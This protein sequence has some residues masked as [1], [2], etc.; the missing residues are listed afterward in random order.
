MTTLPIGGFAAGVKSA[1]ARAKQYKER[2]TS[3]PRFIWFVFPSVHSSEACGNFV[4]CLA[5]NTECY[6]QWHH[7]GLESV[8]GDAILESQLKAAD[9]VCKALLRKTSRLPS[10]TKAV[11]TLAAI[12]CLGY[13]FYL[14]SPSVNPWNWD[15]KLLLS[16]THSFI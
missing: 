1:G 9:H 7:N 16:K 3:S 10:C 12:G 6:K 13:G 5:Q 15:G 11:A 2:G 4:W 14:I 8:Q